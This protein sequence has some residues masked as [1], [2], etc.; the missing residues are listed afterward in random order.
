[1]RFK[2]NRAFYRPSEKFNANIQKVEF[3]DIPGAE[4]YTFENRRGKPAGIA[5]GG[6]RQKP[7]WHY[8]FST[9]EQ[10]QKHIDTWAKG[11]REHES[12]KLER[13]Q[14]RK[15]GTTLEIGDILYESWGY[16]QT[17]VNYYQVVA[18]KGKC[19]VQVRPISSRSVDNS[20]VSPCPDSFKTW[21]VLLSKHSANT[22]EEQEG[23][24][25]W[26][27][28]TGDQITLSSGHNWANKCGPD[29]CHYETPF[30]MGH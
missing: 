18:C 4:V 26:R 6:R 12:Y 27:R 14:E 13:R 24:I 28:A 2:Q 10:R 22:K 3:D 23:A 8:M 29:S 17:N 7:D 5:F 20:H 30:G 9:E 19:M 16:D 11:Q 15:S 21:D 1:M 25:G